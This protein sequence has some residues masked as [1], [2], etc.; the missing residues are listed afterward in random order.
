MTTGFH[1]NGYAID[2]ER[3]CEWELKAPLT[4]RKAAAFMKYHKGNPLAECRKEGS[5]YGRIPYE[6]GFLMILQAAKRIANAC[7][8]K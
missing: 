3:L 7:F 4:G 6:L 1:D 2:C 8:T 5:V